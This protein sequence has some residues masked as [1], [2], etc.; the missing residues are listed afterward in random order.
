MRDRAAL[1]VLESGTF[2]DDLRALP[3]VLNVYFDCP[4]LQTCLRVNGDE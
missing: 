4:D 3:A 2:T 1:E